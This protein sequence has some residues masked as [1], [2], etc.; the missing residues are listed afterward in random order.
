MA[1]GATAKGRASS[2]RFLPY[3]QHGPQNGDDGGR[4]SGGE[5]QRI[6]IAR[7]FLKDAPILVLDEATANVD[8][9]NEAGIRTALYA[10]A[11]GRSVLMIAHRLWAV[12]ECDAIWVLDNGTIVERGQH[13]APVSIEGGTYR[14][15]WEA[16]QRARIGVPQAS[17][18][19]A[20]EDRT[21]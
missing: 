11:E 18:Q 9:E 12:T 20:T 16:Q 7:A 13:D 4:L 8:V 17:D 3:W 14:R 19:V 2:L 21:E 15:M 6:A 5:R 10:L 1:Q